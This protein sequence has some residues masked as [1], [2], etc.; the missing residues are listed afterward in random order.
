MALIRTFWHQI[1]RQ[2][3]ILTMRD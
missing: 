2:V 3:C 1:S